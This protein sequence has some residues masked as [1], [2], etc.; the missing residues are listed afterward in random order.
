MALSR[1]L[2]RRQPADV[3]ALLVRDPQDPELDDFVEAWIRGFHARLERGGPSRRGVVVVMRRV[4][5]AVVVE[6]EQAGV[7]VG[8]RLRLRRPQ[9]ML[10]GPDEGW[11]AWLS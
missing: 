2:R 1:E 10:K 5:D 11:L 8:P 3:G 4:G 7:P 6:F 9:R